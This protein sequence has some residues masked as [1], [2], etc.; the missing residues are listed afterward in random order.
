[1]SLINNANPG[2]SF[3]V[4]LIISR[5]L[6]RNDGV[7]TINDVLGSLRPD[8][9][10]YTD[11]AKKKINEEIN[12]WSK[13][14]VQLWDLNKDVLTL[15]P[16]V[17]SDDPALIAKILRDKFYAVHYTNLFDGEVDQRVSGLKQL[18]AVLSILLALPDFTV[19]S[20][21]LD[22]KKL[23]DIQGR[24]VPQNLLLNDSEKG[25]FLD[26]LYFLGFTEYS[27]GDKASFN[28]DPTRAYSDTIIQ[29]LKEKGGPYLLKDFLD[30]LGGKIPLID[31]GSYNKEAKITISKN[32]KDVNTTI[33][34]SRSL[35]HVLFRM[36]IGGSIHLSDKSDSSDR[37]FLDLPFDE[38]RH[39]SHIELSMES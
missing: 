39:L 20:D 35:S 12:F 36:W 8:E 13:D 5:Y 18:I 16:L 28:I 37:I 38:K 21:N 32:N 19:G 2:S 24:Y 17:T 11:N 34:L 22:K 10:A 1:M 3:E 15:S 23:T 26:W 7:A 30:E 29:I 4:A 9:L 25:V 33:S 14:D 27:I 6:F 31:G